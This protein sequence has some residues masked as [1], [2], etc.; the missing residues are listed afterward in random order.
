M[1][2]ST[3]TQASWRPQLALLKSEVLRFSVRT[4][5]VARPALD[6]IVVAGMF[7]SPTGL[8]QSARLC[9]AALR[10]AGY[11]VAAIDLCEQFKVAGGVPFNDYGSQPKEGPGVIILHINGPWVSRALWQIG[12][13]RT[14][15]KFIIGYWAWEL[16]VMPPNWIQGAHFVHEIWAPS[17]FAGEA[18]ARDVDRPVRIVPHVLPLKAVD[19]EFPNAKLAARLSMGLPDSAFVVAFGFAMLSNFARKNPLAAISAFKEAFGND[20]SAQLVL[21]CLDRDAYPY[22]ARIVNDHIAGCKNI[23][24]ISNVST[25]MSLVIDAADVYL[26]L[27]RS[28]GFGLTLLEAMVAGKPVITTNW[29]GNMDFTTIDDSVLIESELVAVDDPQGVFSR[30]EGRWAEPNLNDAANALRR[31]HQDVEFR[32]RMGVI[33]RVAAENFVLKSKTIFLSAL[34]AAVGATIPG[35]AF[36]HPCNQMSQKHYSSL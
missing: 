24:L 33:A 26:S 35:N 8:G 5:G 1:F 4:A 15:D 14:R 34:H 2:W 29:S 32:V 9:C 23:H 31:L 30:S 21:R 25:P 22:G 36:N 12:R 3:T 19:C 13:A 11:N 7:R 28:E 10:D 18:F 27:H 17:R 6:N 20:P 16:E